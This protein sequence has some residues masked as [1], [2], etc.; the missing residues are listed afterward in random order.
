MLYI[1]ALVEGTVAS[2]QT[3][4]NGAD[5]GKLCR[6]AKRLQRQKGRGAFVSFSVWAVFLA[7]LCLFMSCMH[8]FICCSCKKNGHEMGRKT[9]NKLMK[10]WEA[11]FLIFNNLPL[12][13]SQVIKGSSGD[14][15]QMLLWFIHN[16]FTQ[17]DL[18]KTHQHS[19]PGSF[20]F[21]IWE[22]DGLCVSA[23]S[24]TKIAVIR[25]PRLCWNG[26]IEEDAA[27]Q[28]AAVVEYSMRSKVAQDQ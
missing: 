17:T 24:G 23:T 8:L 28:T 9:W 3:T 27:W 10:G 11:V 7:Y 6:H 13:S 5:S 26:T 16:S 21:F 2:K 12:P 14:E 25:G 15:M 1:L 4:V 20:F 18:D 19:P 22:R